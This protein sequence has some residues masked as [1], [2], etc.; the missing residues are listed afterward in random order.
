MVTNDFGRVRVICID[1]W[2]CLQLGSS[3]VISGFVRNSNTE[4]LRLVFK[5]ILM[6]ISACPLRL[7]LVKLNI[8][9]L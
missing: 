4:E 9:C 5:D 8:Y 6:V 2:V 1:G 7:M 3:P